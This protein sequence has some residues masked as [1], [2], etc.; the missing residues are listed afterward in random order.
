MIFVTCKPNHVEFSAGDKIWTTRD[1]AEWKHI[2]PL[3]IDYGDIYYSS[4]VDSPRDFTK[5]E[6]VIALCQL[7]RPK[8]AIGE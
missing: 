5:N 4:T 2:K 7:L 1:T 6:K 3:L 8:A